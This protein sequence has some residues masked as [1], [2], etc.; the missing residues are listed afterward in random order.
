MHAH[1]PP[2]SQCCVDP[3]MSH[4]FVPAPKGLLK[5]PHDPN[6]IS[7]QGRNA[8]KHL[9]H[10]TYYVV[11]LCNYYVLQRF[12]GTQ[13]PSSRLHRNKVLKDFAP[14]TI[15]RQIGTSKTTFE[16]SSGAKRMDKFKHATRHYRHRLKSTTYSSCT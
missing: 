6:S 11:W 7:W 5:Y 1:E 12:L 10:V 2:E 3:K 8:K 13:G 14:G 16:Y 15:G 4:Q 9:D